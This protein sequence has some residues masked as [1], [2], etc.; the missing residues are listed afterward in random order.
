MHATRA[1]HCYET[2]ACHLDAQ[3]EN[4]RPAWQQC[5]CNMSVE[6]EECLWRFLSLCG[7]VVSVWR[8]WVGYAGYNCGAWEL[9][10]CIACARPCTAAGVRSPGG[11]TKLQSGLKSTSMQF[12]ELSS[13][14][15]RSTAMQEAQAQIHHL[16]I[17][18]HIISHRCNNKKSSSAFKVPGRS[19]SRLL[20]G[21]NPA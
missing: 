20:A 13:S 18:H 8:L 7:R 3:H 1:S 15:I 12:S 21:P 9:A 5:C 10:G 16:H 4:S 14:L 6:V 17:M 19:L 11:W 2:G